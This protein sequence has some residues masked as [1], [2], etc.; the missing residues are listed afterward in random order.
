MHR[1][2]DSWNTLN[3]KALIRAASKSNDS[4]RTNKQTKKKKKKEKLKN[5]N[6]KK[7]ICMDTSND[8]LQARRLGNC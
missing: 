1:Y 4:I 7:T 2:R 3:K 8:K 6:V 5:R